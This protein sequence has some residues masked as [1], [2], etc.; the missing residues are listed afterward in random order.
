[1][2]LKD[3]VAIVTGGANGIGRATVEL[4]AEAGAR[5]AVADRDTRKGKALVDELQ[6]RGAEGLLVPTDVSSDTDVATLVKETTR[7]WGGLDIL[8]NCAGVDITGSVVDTE[9]ER[10]QRVLDVNLASAYRT[11]RFA[12]PHLIARGGGSIVNIASLQGMY[13]WANYAAYAASKA[14][15]IGLTRQ[16]AAEYAGHNVR[17]NAI[18]PGGIATELGANSDQLEPRFAHDPGAPAPA[19]AP[20]PAPSPA[21]AAA[22]RLRRAG[23]PRDVAWAALFLASEEAAY[24]TGHNLVVGGVLSVAL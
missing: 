7:R 14:G 10:W 1:M 21:A 4:F 16:I 17:A 20:A 2:R 22:P 13:G 8:V 11:C 18:S 3:K 6:A 19:A 15:L 9:P 5:V 12:V 24:I 23:L